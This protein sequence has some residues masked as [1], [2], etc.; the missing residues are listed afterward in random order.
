MSVQK[1]END[2]IKMMYTINSKKMAT[3]TETK[4]SS[5]I[6]GELP[7]VLESLPHLR[8][9]RVK[10]VRYRTRGGKMCIVV[11][12]IGNIK[13]LCSHENCD[14]T[15][16]H[17]GNRDRHERTHTGKKPY[18]CDYCDKTFALSGTRDAHERTHT[19]EKPYTC[20]YCDKTF[21]HASNRDTHE[22][23]HTG[24]KP[25]TCDYCDKTFSQSGNR[26]AHEKLHEIQMS[27]K[28]ECPFQDNGLQKAKK[29]D[30]KCAAKMKDQRMLDDHIQRCHTREGIAKKFD[31]EHK[32]AIFLDRNDVSYDRDTANRINF[33]ACKGLLESKSNEQ[34]DDMRISAKPD[35]HLLEYSSL[36]KAF[37]MLG[38]DE[39]AHRSYKCESERLFKITEALTRLNPIPIIFIRF[40]PHA[41]YVD[42]IC[43]DPPLERSHEQLLNIIKS[44][45][46]STISEGLN[47]IWFNYDTIGGRLKIFMDAEL[48]E[49]ERYQSTY[50]AHLEETTI[51]INDIRVEPPQSEEEQ[52]GECVCGQL[53][54]D[55]CNGK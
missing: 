40:N 37:L 32:L 6:R 14:K 3:I 8:K 38:N 10:G 24:K 16:A 18:T 44:L 21:S 53:D 34:G 30:L 13:Y 46:R 23:T 9:N 42:D 2:K 19:G 39:F 26:D 15:F 5:N 54:C 28:I 48:Q 51:S 12:D 47:T 55:D 36:L 20:D 25:Y 22:R 29:G 1:N 49:G 41:Y 4:D 7:N 33:S 52:E 11:D 17:S 35:F 50:I 31:S 27:Y 43:Y 45:D